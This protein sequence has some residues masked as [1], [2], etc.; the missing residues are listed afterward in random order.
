ML[1]APLDLGDVVTRTGAS[2][3]ASQLHLESLRSTHARARF[4]IGLAF[5]CLKSR[6]AD[7]VSAE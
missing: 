4:L 2:N 3:R 6:F 7:D 5:G 1:Y